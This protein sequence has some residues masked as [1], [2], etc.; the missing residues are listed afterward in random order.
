MRIDCYNACECGLGDLDFGDTFYLDGALYLKVQCYFN[1]S[2]SG[3]SYIVDLARGAMRSE[4]DETIVAK[5][6]TKVVAYGD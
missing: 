6:D 2:K 3:Y 4:S 1:P 5:A